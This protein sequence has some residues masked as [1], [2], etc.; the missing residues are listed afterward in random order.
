MPEGRQVCPRCE[1]A[2]NAARARGAENDIDVFS[3][4]PAEA[5]A[6][7]NRLG[8]EFLADHGYDALGAWDDAE[9]CATLEKELAERGEELRYSDF[10]DVDDETGAPVKIL[11]CYA[12]Y[13]RE[14]RCIARSKGMTFIRN[15]TEADAESAGGSDGAK[16]T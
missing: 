16:D 7:V 15:K 6:A 4:L 10:Y 9:K 12:L 11:I 1:E 3:F 5:V 13:D 2:I 8:F 14:G